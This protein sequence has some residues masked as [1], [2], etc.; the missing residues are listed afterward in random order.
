MQFI[1]LVVLI[2]ALSAQLA[3]AKKMWGSR[4]KREAADDIVL[5]SIP[6]TA[7]DVVNR[8]SGAGSTRKSFGASKGTGSGRSDGMEDMLNMYVK[9]FE[10]LLDSDEFESSVNPETIKAMIE[11]FPGASSTPEIATLLN[12]PEMSDPALLRKS[13]RDGLL[14]IKSSLGDIIALLSDPERLSEVIAQLPAEVKPLVEALQSGDVNA[15]KDFVINMPGTT[16]Y[17]YICIVHTSTLTCT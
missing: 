16:L 14:F 8:R 15:L 6:K 2:I 5:P 10:D 4:K 13:M 3:Q 11:Q 17:L 12:S 9:M 1:L 7:H